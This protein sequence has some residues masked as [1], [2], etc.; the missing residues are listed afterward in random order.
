MTACLYRF[1]FGAHPPVRSVRP[2]SV[3]E[4]EL[5]DSDGLGPDLKPWLRQRFDLKK[6]VRFPGNPVY[7][8]IHVTG[9]AP[10]DALEVRFL[11]VMPNRRIARTLI[12]PHH[13]F[14]PDRLVR[15]SRRMIHWHLGRTTARIRNPF[16]ARPPAIKLAPFLGCIATGTK[17]GTSSLDAGPHGGNL[18]LPELQV[19][20]TLWLP[21]RLRGGLLYL[22]DMH[23]AQG[24]GEIVGGGLEVSGLVRVRIGLKKR[25]KLRWPRYQTR[26]GR[27]CIVA[28]P[29]LEKGVQHS[30]VEMI[31]WLTESGM[32]QSDAYMTLSQ[33]CAFR[34]GGVGAR[35]AVVA[36]FVADAK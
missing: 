5:P 3:I 12:A 29:S 9:A 18:D 13:G 2:G 27:G 30:M 31:R 6:G 35:Y 8:P 1:D 4:I 21:V 16:G 15:R 32:N 7:G 34:L 22:G 24:H 25:A 20:S 36:C 11:R 26:V 14:L 28:Q 17:G 19:S 33:T 23:A 10:G